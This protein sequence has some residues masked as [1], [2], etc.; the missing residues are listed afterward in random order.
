MTVM[1]VNETFRSLQGE[2]PSTGQPAVFLRLAN[3]NLS[4][5]WCDT[6]YSWDWKRFDPAVE[7]HQATID[8][9]A[10][11]ITDDLREVGLLIVT[12]GEPLLQQTALVELF[13]SLKDRL[14]RCRIEIETNGTIAPSSEIVAFADLF[15]VSPK[16]ANSGMHEK[17]RIRPKVLSSFPPARTVLKFVVTSLD[18]LKEVAAVRAV[19]GMPAKSTWIMPEATSRDS[20]LL[21]LQ[22]LA[23]PVSD[24]SYSLSS[25]LHIMLWGDARGT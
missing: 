18:D 1:F 14:P 11:K 7:R 13:A 4:C 5:V 9:V 3:C 19:S 21:K 6:R 20:L 22:E 8:Q 16:L 25:R 2:G 24:A 17:R 10:D 15:V 12:G 23:G